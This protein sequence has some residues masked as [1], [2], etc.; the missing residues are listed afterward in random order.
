MKRFRAKKSFGQNFLKQQRIVDRI[1]REA[2]LRG[3]ETVVEVGPGF[4]ILT[5]ALSQH[6]K[7]IIAIEKDDFLYEQLAGSRGEGA[8]IDF[9]HADALDVAPPSKEYLLVS[10]IPYSITSPLLDHYIRNAYPNL[11]LRAVLLV[12][13]EVA[14]KVCAKP[15]RMNV[16]ALHVQTFGAPRYI[17]TV[18]RRNFSPIPKVD[19]AVIVIDFKE[20]PTFSPAYFTK[21]FELIHAAF[22]TKRKMLRSSLPRELLESAGINESRRPET[23]GID[24]WHRL[25]ALKPS[26]G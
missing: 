22:R 14:E 2:N 26:V 6:A 10:N 13:K 5:K 18:S 3:D 24:E 15:P 11:P 8:H 21:Y 23:L 19:S 17:A 16:L 7:K 4:G 1:I 9:I 12:Q 25:A 20:G